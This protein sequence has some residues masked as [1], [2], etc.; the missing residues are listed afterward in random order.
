V[1]GWELNLHLCHILLRFSGCAVII[2]AWTSLSFELAV[3]SEMQ[4]HLT[5]YDTKNKPLVLLGW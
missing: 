4:A 2:C 5:E 1:R 3:G